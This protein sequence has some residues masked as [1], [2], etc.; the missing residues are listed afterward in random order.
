[1]ESRKRWA[2][3]TGPE[4][5]EPWLGSEANI[6]VA[7]ESTRKQKVLDRGEGGEVD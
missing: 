2:L 7:L 3:S 5:A 6:H 1:M 4:G